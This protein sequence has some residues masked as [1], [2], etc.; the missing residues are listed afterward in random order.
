VLPTETMVSN[1]FTGNDPLLGSVPSSNS[2]Q[3]VIDNVLLAKAMQH[4]ISTVI[5]GSF[6]IV[7]AILVIASIMWNAHSGKGGALDLRYACLQG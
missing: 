1:V 3:E 4:R 2:T 5:T 6:N 7:T